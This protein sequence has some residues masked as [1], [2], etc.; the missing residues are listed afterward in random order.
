MIDEKEKLKLEIERLKLE[1]ENLKLSKNLSKEDMI[2][3]VQKGHEQ[4]EAAMADR[5][6]VIGLGIIVA[7]FIFIAIVILNEIKY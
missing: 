5:G 4:A 7:I 6:L 1:N 2:E 3:A